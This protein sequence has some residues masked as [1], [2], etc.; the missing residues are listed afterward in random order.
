MVII[1]T[2]IFYIITT[3]IIDS[4]TYQQLYTNAIGARHSDV[5]SCPKL[6][7]FVVFY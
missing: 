1:C 2:F 7:V 6:Q 4:L 5:G 3:F